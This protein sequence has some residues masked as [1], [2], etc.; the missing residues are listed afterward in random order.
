MDNLPQLLDITSKYEVV[1]CHDPLHGHETP[2]QIICSGY[3]NGHYVELTI[4]G[5]RFNA[6]VDNDLM[7]KV[8]VCYETA[9]WYVE[10]KTQEPIREKIG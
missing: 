6:R 4:D 10:Q 2:L 7:A 9:R 8:H 3:R 1:E 5:Q